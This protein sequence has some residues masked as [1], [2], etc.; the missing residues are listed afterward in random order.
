ME[1]VDGNQVL[2]RALPILASSGAFG[3]YGL[4]RNQ[5]G[6]FR[7]YITRKDPL[8]KLTRREGMP[9][10]L[11]PDDVAAFVTRVQQGMGASGQATD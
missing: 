10:Y 4:F 8:V 11:S 2:K 9:V 7:A 6:R 3:M 5:E 1:L